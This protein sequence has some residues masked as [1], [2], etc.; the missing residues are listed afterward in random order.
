M[1]RRWRRVNIWTLTQRVETGARR[2]WHWVQYTEPGY[3]PKL[4]L[5]GPLSARTG[6][7]EFRHRSG[8]VWLRTVK[9]GIAEKKEAA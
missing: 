9:A 4:A 8:G 7:L 6:L 3:A 2:R 5:M 1:N